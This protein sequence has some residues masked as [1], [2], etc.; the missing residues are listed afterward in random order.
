MRT[1]DFAPLYKS[2][3]GFDRLASLLESAN[4]H[5]QSQPGFPPYNIELTGESQYRVSVAVAGFS[6]DE[7]DIEVEQG[8]LK[9][10][11][12]KADKEEVKQYLHQGIA[13]RNFERKFQLEDHVKVTGAR[14]A[15]GLLHIEL[16]R[17]I[18]EAIKPRK[19]AIGGPEETPTA[20]L[21]SVKS[22]SEV[23]AA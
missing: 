8:V 1:F 23:D 7:L 12:K 21:E 14:L 18:P 20:K 15:D 16:V 17:E 3:V 11:G 4:R 13:A 19:I 9:V 22:E 5:E 2:A 6:T 10:V